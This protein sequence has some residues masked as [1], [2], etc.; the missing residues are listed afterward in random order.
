MGL[1]Y[2]SSNH[3]ELL[4]DMIAD[5][6]FHLTKLETPLVHFVLIQTKFVKLE[7]I[8]ALYMVGGKWLELWGK[9]TVRHSMFSDI[10]SRIQS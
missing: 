3:F 4:F 1:N 9:P 10:N 8:P 5:I 6:T 2:T 7:S